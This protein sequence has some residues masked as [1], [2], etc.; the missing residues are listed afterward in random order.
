M[1]RKINLSISVPLEGALLKKINQLLTNLYKK[2]NIK[3][4]R[5][6]NCRRI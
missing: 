6:K 2:Y 5:N 1:R 3:F 4:I